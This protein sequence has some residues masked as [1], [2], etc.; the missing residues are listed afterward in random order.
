MTKLPDMKNKH[1]LPA[2]IFLLI[3]SGC[4][5]LS[6]DI[7]FYDLSCE[8]LNN[9]DGIGTKEPAFGWKIASEVNGTSQKAYQVLVASDTR[10]LNEKEAD[11]WNSGKVRSTDQVMVIYQGKELKS[12]SVCYWK[13]RIWDQKNN[14]SEWSPVSKFSISL[15]NESDWK[16]E[17]ILLKNNSEKSSSP[18]FYKSFEIKE[19]PS[20]SFLYVNS[21]GYHDVYLNG[22]KVGNM[23]LAP[24]VTQ[25]GKRSQVIAYD[26]TSL[27][28]P[29]KNDLVIW[30]GRGWYAPG[31]PGVVTKGPVI[32]AQ[33][34]ILENEEWNTLI[35]TDTTWKARRSGYYTLGTWKPGEFGGEEID[36]SMLLP[37][38]TEKSIKTADW[39]SVITVNIPEHKAT[40]QLTEGNIILDTLK[41]V[42]VTRTGDKKWMADIGTTLTGLTEIRFGNLKKNQR[43]EL[44]FCDHLDKDGKPVD[45]GQTDYY[46][47]SGIPGETFRNRFNYHGFRYIFINNL[48]SEPNK[49]DISAF[50]VR[51]GYKLASTFECSDP[52]M[53]AIH[54]MIFY[55]L[56]NLSIGGYMVDCPQ[57]ERL[58]Y[59]GDGNASTETAQTMF[60]LAPLYR[61]W[62]QAWGDCLREDGGMPHT[63]PNPYRAGGGPYW[64][65]FII[66]VSWRT[67]MNYGDKRI[68]EKYYPVMR[69]WIGYAD[70][71]SSSGLLEGW[72]ETDY[73]SW[74]LGDWASPEGTDHTDK[75]SIKLVNNCFMAVCFET[76]EKISGVLGKNEESAMYA[77]RKLKIAE[78]INNELFDKTNNIYGSGIQVDLT[79]PLLAGIVPADLKETI[80]TKLR[81]VI[82]KE[83]KGHIATGLV[84]I[85][86]FTEWSTINGEADLMYSM[87]KK[88]DYPG[89]LYM[90][91]NGATTT[92][93]H[94]NGARSRI[95]NCYNG[96]GS[97]F[98]Q[99]VGGIRKDNDSPGYQRII[100]DPDIPEGLTWAKIMKETPYGTVKVSWVREKNSYNLD[101]SIPASTEAKVVF[102]DLF[103]TIIMN[104][105]DLKVSGDS[106]IIGSGNY[107]FVCT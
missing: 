50:P 106:V 11:L 94:W 91:D 92:W 101:I 57:I 37:D 64:C 17:Y 45:Q 104:G 56:Q 38:L 33:M 59:G 73:R 107:S 31:L 81:D 43:I 100:I 52:D 98:Y 5:I 35:K 99:S 97:W 93:E 78:L 53:N 13:V 95:H 44:Q 72:P 80:T 16:A 23:V 86:V 36:A 32:R 24:A 42:S 26:V 6:T 3:I 46:L 62:L 25:F 90:I 21:L 82:L 83:H 18:Q 9:P 8:N 85:P 51:T 60:D 69:K 29:G 34:D 22:Y 105:K 54:G 88:R 66:T 67:Y 63:A 74:Y 102:P 41:A 65:G 96:I 19:A 40:A 7:N 48:D 87:L 89:Y 71:Y 77:D 20:G 84:G 4:T 70:K 1:L 2:C 76:M 79:Y 39:Q 68:L 58:G 28:K 15:L 10:L 61:N 12:R 14:S 27:V 49:E 55:T 30:A 103:R 75:R 47:A